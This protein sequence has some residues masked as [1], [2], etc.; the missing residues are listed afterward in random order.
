MTEQT[1]QNIQTKQ[2]NLL[3]K[4]ESLEQIDRDMQDYLKDQ[5]PLAEWSYEFLLQL[6]FSYAA[7]VLEIP[8]DHEIIQLIDD[9]KTY[10]IYD[11]T[12]RP[13]R[14]LCPTAETLI[15]PMEKK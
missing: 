4:P 8:D 1:E 6:M 7:N 10:R 15:I 5:E 11:I 2:I 9:N 13:D 3:S 12:H 14:Y